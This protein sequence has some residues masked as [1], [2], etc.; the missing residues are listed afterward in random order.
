MPFRSTWLIGAGLFLVGQT[1]GLVALA[2]NPRKCTGTGSVCASGCYR[3]CDYEQGVSCCD[4]IPVPYAICEAGGQSCTEGDVICARYHSKVGGPCAGPIC[5][6]F[7]G[8]SNY[9]ILT[10]GCAGEP[11][12]DP[13]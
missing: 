7:V 1:M 11:P 4:F 12:P 6:G 8:A 9:D 13:G 10:T 5:T 3:P 2:D